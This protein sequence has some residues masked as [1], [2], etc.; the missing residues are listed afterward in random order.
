[1]KADRHQ[2]EGHAE[3]YRKDR[4]APFPVFHPAVVH[5]QSLDAVEQRLDEKRQDQADQQR[6]KQVRPAEMADALEQI[7]NLFMFDLQL[8]GVFQMLILAAA[9]FPEI[10][11]KRRDAARRRLQDFV[12]EED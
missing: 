4:T 2:C 6:G 1:M 10:P 8:R 5:N 9:A 11:A 3:T 12:P 7:R